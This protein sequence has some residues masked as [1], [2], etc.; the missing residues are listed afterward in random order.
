MSG[1][2]NCICYCTTN[3]LLCHFQ[4]HF[5]KASITLSCT[6]NR[7]AL[8]PHLPA[9]VLGLGDNSLLGILCGSSWV[10]ASLLNRI[11]FIV[12]ILSSI[13]YVKHDAKKHCMCNFS[14]HPHKHLR[15]KCYS[16]G[17][18]T[19]MLQLKPGAET[20]QDCT[21]ESSMA[22]IKMP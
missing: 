18:R 12:M 8:T 21:A 1:C 10:P 4:V 5:A 15:D 11:M 7:P 2:R 13:S 9:S 19:V 3:V 22:R 16:Y 20:S 6:A 14:F 17:L